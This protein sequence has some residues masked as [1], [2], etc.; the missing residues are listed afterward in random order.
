PQPP[1]PQAL[2]RMVERP[3]PGPTAEE[4]A[5]QARLQRME[6]QNRMAKNY[7]RPI[8]VDNVFETSLVNPDWRR[9]QNPDARIRLNAFDRALKRERYDQLGHGLHMP[10][11][12]PFSKDREVVVDRYSRIR[13]KAGRM[14]EFTDAVEVPA[15]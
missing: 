7:P 14:N 3:L 10:V 8:G 2:P 1:A 6:E 15:T 12:G 9:T 13:A 5:R 11:I 4:E